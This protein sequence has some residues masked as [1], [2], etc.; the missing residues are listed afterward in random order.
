M[1]NIKIIFAG[2]SFFSEHYLNALINSS[3]QIIGV[4]TQPDTPSGR[5]QKITFSPVKILSQKKNIPLFQPLNLNEEKFQY[6]LSI[7]NADMMIV[8]AYG[9]ILPKK[10][11]KMFPIGCINVH[12]SLLPRWRGATPIQSAIMHGD[13]KTGITIIKM[14]EKIDTGKIIHSEICSISPIDTTYTLSLK[15]IHIGIKSLLK[16]LQNIINETIKTIKQDEKNCRISYKIYKKEG[17]LNFH[18]PAIKLERLIR[19]FNPWPTCHFKINEKIIKVWKAEI[20]PIHIQNYSIG[21]I[22]KLNKQ[23]I[24]IQTGYQLLNIKKLQIPGKKIMTS[25]QIFIS[26]KNLF[27]KNMILI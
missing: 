8:V 10:I 18:F 15:L 22:V 5:G 17:L 24:Q 7:L 2:T 19:A 9:K 1:K 11:L 20:I 3:Y 26:Q 21:E 25:E 4:I 23:G 13:K 27:K 12:P 14:N 16:I 6:Q